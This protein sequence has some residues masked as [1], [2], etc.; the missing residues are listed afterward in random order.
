M[1]IK[2][3]RATGGDRLIPTS[4]SEK[5]SSDQAISC[6]QALQIARLDAEK[7]YRDLSPFRI[8]IVLEPDGWHI[9]YEL[10][11]LGLRGGGPHYVIDARD[12]TILS[13]RYEQ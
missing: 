8:E 11:N 3:L 6:D 4:V 9:D 7:A 13:K 1:R 2:D 12:G 10:K 5:S